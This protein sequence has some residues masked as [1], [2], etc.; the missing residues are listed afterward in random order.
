MAQFQELSW[1]FLETPREI[2]KYVSHNIRC[3]RSIFEKGSSR[4]TSQVFYRSGHLARCVV[5]CS[6]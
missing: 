3:C 5:S 1:N 2:A 6:I 4:I